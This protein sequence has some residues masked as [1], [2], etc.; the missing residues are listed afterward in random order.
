MIAAYGLVMCEADTDGELEPAEAIDANQLA[1][2][3]HRID[4]LGSNINLPEF[5]TFIGV[6]RLEDIRTDQ[7]KMVCHN[8]SRKEKNVQRSGGV[9]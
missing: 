8:L 7:W 4:A 5:L 2:L 6:E 1:S 3:K 9:K